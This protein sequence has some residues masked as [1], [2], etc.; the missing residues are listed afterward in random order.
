MTRRL[1]IVVIAAGCCLGLQPLHSFAGQDSTACAMP[2]HHQLDFWLG[3][4][5][6]FAP[7]GTGSSTS[8]V[9]L[10][11]DQCVVVER[12]RDGAN[13][14]G[15]NLF[16]YSADDRRWHGFFA[17]NRGRVHVFVDG[18]V[19]AGVAEFRGPSTT[20]NGQAVV[21][22][23]RIILKDPT[24]VEQVWEKSTDHGLRWTTAFR[25][26]YARKTP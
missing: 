23:V 9:T 20:E 21:N 1:G 16:G 17:D 15:E 25:G 14:E 19:T 11:L 3:E 26:E 8:T 4:W 2:E 13:H 6:I 18:K 7:G 5:A 24:K 10:S 22:R 12:W